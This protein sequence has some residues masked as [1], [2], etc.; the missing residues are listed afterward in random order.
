MIL[1]D[2]TRD[3]R[4]WAWGLEVAVWGVGSK[5]NT[6]WLFIWASKPRLAGQQERELDGRPTPEPQPSKP[7]TVVTKP[8]KWR[9]HMFG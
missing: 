7:S 3:R 9:P 6:G 2:F 8:K 4:F 5:R 1:N